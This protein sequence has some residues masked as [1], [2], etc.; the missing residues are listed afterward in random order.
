VLI[1]YHLPTLF[2]HGSSPVENAEALQVLLEAL[3]AIDMIHLIHHPQTPKLADPAFGVV[4]GRTEEWMSIPSLWL[5]TFGDCKSLTAMRIAELRRAGKVAKPVFR[6]R[7]NKRGGT[8]YH[9]LV[10]VGVNAFQDPSKECGMKD[11]EWAYFDG[12]RQ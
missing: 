1:S 5:N 8:D 2:V 6:F 12:P 9:I 11:S 7:K 10:Q 3:I 4:Y